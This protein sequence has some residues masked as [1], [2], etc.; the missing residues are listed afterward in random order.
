[1]DSD[2]KAKYRGLFQR[3]A[4]SRLLVLEELQR[5]KEKM[6]QTPFPFCEVDCPWLTI[7]LDI[8]ASECI[9]SLLLSLSSEKTGDIDDEKLIRIQWN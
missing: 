6:C 9:L 5:L 1:M 8:T 3:N 2:S 7:C 4:S